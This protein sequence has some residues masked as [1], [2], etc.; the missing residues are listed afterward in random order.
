MRLGEDG[1]MFPAYEVEKKAIELSVNAL[2][3]ALSLIATID[4][5]AGGKATTLAAGLN[6]A[7]D[8]LRHYGDS[9]DGRQ[10]GLTLTEYQRLAQRTCNITDAAED[11]ILNGCMGLNGEAGECIDIMKKYR[12]QG[13]ELD[14]G[15]MIEELGDVLWYCAELAEGLGTTLGEAAALN[16]EKLR[17]RYPE[18]FDPERSRNRE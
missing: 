9:L 7:K 4:S 6:M 13:H 15:H 12:F 11:K 2:D 5:E 17:A 18:G 1:E 10:R 14:K 8:T 16:I 3:K